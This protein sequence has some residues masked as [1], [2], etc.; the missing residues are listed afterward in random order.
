[1]KFQLLGV[2]RSL[3]EILPAAAKIFLDTYFSNVFLRFLQ[4]VPNADPR[5]ANDF[6][7]NRVFLR[8]EGALRITRETKAA[9]GA[10]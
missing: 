2:R 4:K 5:L 1:M 8:P 6:R 10:T 7:Q 3:N 9:S